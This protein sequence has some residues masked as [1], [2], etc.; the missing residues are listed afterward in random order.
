M[1]GIPRGELGTRLDTRNPMLSRKTKDALKAL[2]ITSVHKSSAA[3][4]A[5]VVL[6]VPG[7]VFAQSGTSTIA[8]I[9][10][11]A[12]GGTIPGA[13]VRVVNEDTGVDSALTTN[14]EGLYRAGSLVPGKYRV[15]IELDGFTPVVRRPIVVEVGQTI[16]VDVTLEIAGQSETVQVTGRA[17]PLVDTQSSSSRRP[18]RSRCSTRCRCRTAPHRRSLRLRPASS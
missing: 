18:S 6:T 14:G 8:G 5:L 4:F 2:L 7:A 9:V 16:A 17:M 15:E 11:D 12:T 13:T 10:K 1:G 3:V